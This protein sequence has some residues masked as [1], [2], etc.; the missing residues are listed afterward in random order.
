[1][2][3]FVAEYICYDDG[4]HLRKYARNKL[5]SEQT[6]TAVKLASLEIVVDKMHMSGHV[7]Q[8]CKSNCDPKLFDDLHNVSSGL[9]HNILVSLMHYVVVKLLRL[10]PRYVNN[11]FP[12]CLAME[13]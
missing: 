2:P 5:R 7:D 3:C 4:Y 8:W 1:M 11:I 6:P 10:T 12:G 9:A 13:K